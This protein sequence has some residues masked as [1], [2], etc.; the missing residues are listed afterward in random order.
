MYHGYGKILV[1]QTEG[2]M[3]NFDDHTTCPYGAISRTQRS[4]YDYGEVFKWD[5]S[6]Y[7]AS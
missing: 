2:L 6:P 4:S 3:K 5:C 1:T 7:S